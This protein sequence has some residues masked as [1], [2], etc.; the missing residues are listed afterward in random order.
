MVGRISLLITSILMILSCKKPDTLDTSGFSKDVCNCYEVF[1]EEKSKLDTT[2]YRIS[3]DRTKNIDS[4]GVILYKCI[5]YSI[6][7]SIKQDSIL[8]SQIR[9]D[10]KCR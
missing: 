4:L 10:M 8:M 2:H 7:D 6:P 9:T 5:E 3:L 1:H